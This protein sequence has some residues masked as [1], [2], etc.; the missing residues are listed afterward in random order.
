MRR[1]GWKVFNFSARV[2]VFAGSPGCMGVIYFQHKVLP[3][4]SGV[5]IPGRLPEEPDRLGC[6][7]ALVLSTPD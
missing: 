4:N 1:K 7:R 2:G 3:W 5:G 6:S